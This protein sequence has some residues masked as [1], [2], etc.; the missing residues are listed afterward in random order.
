M[1]CVALV[2]FSFDLALRNK[3]TSE[4]NYIELFRNIDIQIG[5]F[6]KKC[7]FNCRIGN[8]DEMRVSAMRIASMFGRATIK[9]S[10]KQGAFQSI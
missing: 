4:R 5:Y 3:I 6:A 8:K 10:P 1:R 7:T 9:F 2:D